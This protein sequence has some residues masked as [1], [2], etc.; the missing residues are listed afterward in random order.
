[1]RARRVRRDVIARGTNAAALMRADIRRRGVVECAGCGLTILA[2]AVDV[3]HILPLAKGGED[4]P[5][6]VQPLCRPCH[7]SKTR[8]DFAFTNPPF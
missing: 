3:D 2:S 8:D 5:D 6:N 1:M 7:K 4:V